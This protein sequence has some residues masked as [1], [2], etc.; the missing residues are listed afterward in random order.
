MRIYC[1]T[2]CSYAYLLHYLLYL[3]VS[4]ILL[5]VVMRIYHTTC[6]SYAY[7]PYYLM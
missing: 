7:L 1:T 4:T 2:C 3:C 5:A 6:C